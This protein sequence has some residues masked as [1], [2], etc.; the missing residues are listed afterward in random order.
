MSLSTLC[1]LPFWIST[2]WILIILFCSGLI[3]FYSALD[4]TEVDKLLDYDLKYSNFS[5]SPIILTYIIYINILYVKIVEYI[6]H[7]IFHFNYKLAALGPA[8]LIT[9]ILLRLVL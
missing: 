8:V 2:M 6:S 5:N 3:R 1:L 7:H 9:E 4:S